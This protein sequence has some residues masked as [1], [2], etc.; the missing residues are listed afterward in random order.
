MSV[1]HVALAALL[2]LAVLG[3][4]T[5]RGPAAGTSTISD[6]C[7]PADA[8]GDAEISWV[9]FV[10]VN[11]LSYQ[12]TFA[13]A[14]TVTRSQ[15]GSTV[16]TVKCKI[17]DVVGNPDYHPR[18]GDAAFLPAGTELREINGYRSDF[19]L[20]AWDDGAW[21]V[22]EVDDVPDAVEGEDMLDLRDKVVRVHL[23]GGDRG[24]RIIKTVDDKFDVTSI[25]ESVLAARVL[26]ET[27]KLY[28]RLGD[29]SPVFV[30]FEMIDGT[31][32]QRAWHVR[33]GVIWRRIKAP[34]ALEKLL[35]P[36]QP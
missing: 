20:A 19:R 33:A 22:Y 16:L 13:P 26:P 1:R 30:R 2:L 28:D 35:S 11:G 3:C 36:P 32:V 25:V 4:G 9:P 18:D 27:S 14:A 8:D 7:P 6:A 23:V 12:A 15:L 21:H 5:E 10:R 29:E 31:A 17:A 24:E 34:A